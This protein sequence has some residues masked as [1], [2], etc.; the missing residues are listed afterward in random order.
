MLVAGCASVEGASHL[1][2]QLGELGLLEVIGSAQVREEAE[3]ALGRKLPSAL[4]A[5]R[6]LADAAVHWVPN[7][8]TDSLSE[9]AGQAH[10]EDVAILV[11][12]IHAEADVFLTF[13]TRHYRQRS[14]PPHIERP[15]AFLQ[16]L[17]ARL[18]DLVDPQTPTESD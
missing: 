6:Q 15:G 13:N 12:A 11:A 7:P 3:R 18:Q 14:A 1:L 16:R 2:L 17:R 9:H 5:F 4:P 8:P 10:R